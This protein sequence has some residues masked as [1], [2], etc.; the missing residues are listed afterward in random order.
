M[1]KGKALDVDWT[2]WGQREDGVWEFMDGESPGD[3]L[4]RLPEMWWVNVFQR[5]EK[6]SDI[7][8]KRMCVVN[9][10]D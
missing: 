4:S 9:Y 6:G 8:V 5:S 2:A 1:V 7:I 10:I 3:I